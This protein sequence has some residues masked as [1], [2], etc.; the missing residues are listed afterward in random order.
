HF[1]SKLKKHMSMHEAP[2][3]GKFVCSECDKEFD[4]NRS[5]Q[6]HAYVHNDIKCG[7]CGAALKSQ[8]SLAKHYAEY[9]PGESI[10][11]RTKEEMESL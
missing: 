9:H 6:L 8:E 2:A 1:P 11:G 5:L 4:T 7:T 10:V 3:R